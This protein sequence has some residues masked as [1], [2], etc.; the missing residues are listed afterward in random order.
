MDDKIPLTCPRCKNAWEQSLRA[1]ER[2][3]DIYRS[4]KGPAQPEKPAGKV[5]NYRAQCPVC[6]TYVI[7]TVEEE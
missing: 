5:A 1:L 6:G 4:T 7:A 2:V 3:D